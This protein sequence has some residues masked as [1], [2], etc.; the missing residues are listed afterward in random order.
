MTGLFD[1]II[2]EHPLPLPDFDEEDLEDIGNKE[3]NWAESEWQTKDLG[4]MLDVYTIEEDGQ[5]YRQKT[6]W[7]EDEDAPMGVSAEDG[8]IEKFEKTGE[9]NFY[10]VVLGKK[11]DHW[12]EFKAVIWKGDLKEL[13]LVEYKKE[14]NSDRLEYQEQMQA[15]INKDKSFEKKWYAKPYLVY[16]FCLTRPLGLLR[17]MIGSIAQITWKIERWMP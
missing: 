5:I 6:D 2:C 8:G 11:C 7:R 16:R 10:N 15:Q 3:A 1:T 12:L 14:D 13:N 9:I 17:Y 4:Q